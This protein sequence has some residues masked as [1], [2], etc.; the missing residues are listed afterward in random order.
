MDVFDELGE[1]IVSTGKYA[2]EKAKEAAELAKLNGQLAKEEFELKK[3]YYELGRFY[4]DNGDVE[5]DFVEPY[6]AAVSNK[7]AS[8]ESIRKQIEAAKN[9]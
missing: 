7:K 5:A 9:K 6:I 1:K 2:G 4:Y 3:A 8:I